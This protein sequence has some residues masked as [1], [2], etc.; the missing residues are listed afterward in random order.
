MASFASTSELDAA[1]TLG[2]VLDWAQVAGD[3]GSDTTLRGAF[4]KATG[5][6]ELALP[7]IFGII[8]SIDF[9]QVVNLMTINTGTAENPEKTPITLFQR[10]ALLN[11]GLFCRLKTGLLDQPVVLVLSSSAVLGSPAVPPVTLQ[12]SVAKAKLSL[13]LRQGDDTEVG[14][15]GDTVISSG[16]ARWERIFGSGS[17]PS[18]DAECTEA[19]L[20]CLK[21]LVDAGQA[22]SVDFALWGPHGQRLERK[23][24]LS[25]A[26]FDKDGT[27]RMVETAGPPTLA[28]W[29][30]S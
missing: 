20:S 14:L 7:R 5:A 25:G 6:T 17:R 29:M 1:L 11:V 9:D 27:I 19:Q 13:I 26:V 4:L 23:L 2:Q 24:R 16:Y 18:S 30:L 28:A 15:V 10:G 3:Q 8:P 22:P 12:P 21:F